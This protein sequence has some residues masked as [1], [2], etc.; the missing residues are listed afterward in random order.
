MRY[1]YIVSYD[2]CDPKRWRQVFKTMN[3]YGEHIQLSVFQ[4]ELTKADKWRMMG[5]LNKL[6][7]HDD[8][9]ILIINI[10]PVRG[11]AEDCIESL[12]KPY[13]GKVREPV[14]V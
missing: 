7:H 9:Q 4:C 2:I 6:I 8:D 12:G 1:A 5:K 11:R 3:G 14:V 10:G 13:E